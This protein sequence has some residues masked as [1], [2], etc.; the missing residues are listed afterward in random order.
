MEWKKRFLELPKNKL[1]MLAL[2]FI[3][4]SI[5]AVFA[6]NVVFKQGS[7]TV[8]GGLDLKTAGP[9]VN[10]IST[11]PSAATNSN[12]I[13]F[14]LLSS[15]QEREFGKIEVVSSEIA[16]ASREG[17][18]N[19]LTASGGNLLTRLTIKGSRVGIGTTS[20][21]GKLHI[22]SPDNG[23]NAGIRIED[24]SSTNY[25]D[26]VYDDRFRIGYNGGTTGG[27]IFS[28]LT[29]GRLRIEPKALA[30]TT[31]APS[32]GDIYVHDSGALC[33]YDGTA[34]QKA[35]GA[36]VATCT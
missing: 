5:V 35:A 1:L 20:P 24:D 32:L 4:V 3:V 30:P 12:D 26:I 9:D 23:W 31:P 2:I 11:T 22:K 6:G 18:I 7:L 16:D 27:T 14:R 19:F 10:I 29:D 13:F 25:F 34:W 33:F 28:I 15:T 8:E 36:A 21:L 17:T